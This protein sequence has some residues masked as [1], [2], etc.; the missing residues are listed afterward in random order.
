MRKSEITSNYLYSEY[1]ALSRPKINK[2][3]C[4]D[5]FDCRHDEEGITAVVA[6]GLGSGI[7]A[8][9][10]SRFACNHII[11]TVKHSRFLYT[12]TN[13]PATFPNPEVERNSTVFPS[14]SII[15]HNKALLPPY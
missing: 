15:T 2:N 13:L 9:I 11:S 7:K 4:G 5:Y 3:A 6:D 1:F 14:I 10:A 8:S 12:K